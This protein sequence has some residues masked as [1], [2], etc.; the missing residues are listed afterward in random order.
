M[1]PALAAISRVVAP[2]NERSEKRSTAAATIRWRVA[3]ADGRVTRSPVRRSLGHPGTVPELFI[4]SG[5]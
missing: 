4:R 2:S 3:S 5:S 1:T